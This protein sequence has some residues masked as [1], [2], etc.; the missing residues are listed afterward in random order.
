VDGKSSFSPTDLWKARQIKEYRRANGLCYKC[1]EKFLPDHKC[2]TGPVG[3]AAAQLTALRDTGL[4][5]GGGI[6]IDDTR[7]VLQGHAPL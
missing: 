2:A 6:L 1:G 3:A 5:D 4:G 7:D